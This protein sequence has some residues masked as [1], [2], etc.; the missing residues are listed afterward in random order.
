MDRYG[1]GYDADDLPEDEPLTRWL[2]VTVSGENRYGY[3][4]A[5]L[6]EAKMRAID[7]IDDPIFSEAPVAIVDL[8]TGRVRV[9]AFYRVAWQA[10]PRLEVQADEPA[11]A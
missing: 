6:A 2:A 5:T 10:R 11:I 1:F 3:V 8:D 9:P 4:H 7:N